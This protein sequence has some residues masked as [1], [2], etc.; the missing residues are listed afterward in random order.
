M[1]CPVELAHEM[2][3][4]KGDLGLTPEGGEHMFLRKDRV[5]IGNSG[6]NGSDYEAGQ[7]RRSLG[8]IARDT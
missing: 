5:E 4:C 2:S 8:S 7:A 6:Y 1:I 3:A